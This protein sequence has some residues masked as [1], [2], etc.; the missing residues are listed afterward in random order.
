MDLLLQLI[1]TQLELLPDKQKM[2]LTYIDWPVISCSAK[3]ADF[4]WEKQCLP[5]W[6]YILVSN[7]TKYSYHEIKITS[8]SRKGTY[9]KVI[10]GPK[11]NLEPSA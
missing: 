1:S 3:R 6:L 7:V 2:R 4:L 5:E 11:A 8:K 10:L 9:Y